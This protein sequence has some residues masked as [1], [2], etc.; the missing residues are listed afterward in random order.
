MRRHDAGRI[1]KEE[2][3]AN[4]RQAIVSWTAARREAKKIE[5]PE[6]AESGFRRSGQ[7][8]PEMDFGGP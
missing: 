3:Q 5:T 2:L 1:T 8:Y 7:A 4:C 6:T